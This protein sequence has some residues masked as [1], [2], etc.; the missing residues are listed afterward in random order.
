[1]FS[2]TPFCITNPTAATPSA[3]AVS[4][5]ATAPFLLLGCTSGSGAVV[6]FQYVKINVA[7]A[8]SNPVDVVIRMDTIQRY[9]SGGTALTPTSPI[10]NYAGTSKITSVYLSPTAK[11]A[12]AARIIYQGR[13]P[14]NNGGNLFLRWA[15]D[16]VDQPQLGEVGSMLIHVVDSAAAV[17]PSVYFDIGWVE[18]T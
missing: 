16:A 9:S 2:G 18:R 13:I 15:E 4:L 3:G 10:V 14:A 5:S 11:A 17:A 6:A 12:S 7:S 1:M 8:V